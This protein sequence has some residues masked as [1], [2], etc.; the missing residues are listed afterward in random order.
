ML[1]TLPVVPLHTG[2]SWAKHSDALSPDRHD[3]VLG[4]ARRDKG[5]GWHAGYTSSDAPVARTKLAEGQIG[6]LIPRKRAGR[7]TNDRRPTEQRLDCRPPEYMDKTCMTV[8][9]TFS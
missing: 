6:V 1:E 5:R 2:P 7:E 8:V 9:L 3:A 4:H